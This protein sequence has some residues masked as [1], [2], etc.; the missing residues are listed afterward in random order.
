MIRAATQRSARGAPAVVRAQ[1]LAPLAAAALA[2]CASSGLYTAPRTLPPHQFQ[3][4][5]APEVVAL[6][7][8]AR[9]LGGA[10]TTGFTI[11]PGVNYAARYGL[12][13][14]LEFGARINT[15]M[16]TGADLKV[17]FV[18]SRYLDLALDPGFATFIGIAWMF[19]VPLLV[20]LNVSDRFQL[21]LAP[22]GA[23]AL[24]L[25]HVGQ[26]T[27]AQMGLVGASGF[28]AGASVGFRLVTS[29][30]V[31]IQ[32]EYTLM[33]NVANTA[34]VFQTLGVNVAFGAQP[35]YSR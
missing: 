11:A 7:Q 28:Y 6:P 29:A 30:S 18:R 32:P 34:D 19:H 8:R 33:M 21:L 23:Y 25:Q 24:D 27:T 20:G 14:A 16:V 4:N 26:G 9:D 10:D 5:L 12:T 31:S 15:S 17:Q 13:G 1:F 22:R 3:H 2:A 35:E